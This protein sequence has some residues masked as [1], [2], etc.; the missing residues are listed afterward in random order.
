MSP[1]TGADVAAA[2]GPSVA[3]V[4]A[5][6][7]EHVAQLEGASDTAAVLD[8]SVAAVLALL[9]AS[10]VVVVQ[11]AGEQV[12]APAGRGLTA[13]QQSWFQGPPSGLPGWGQL[14]D[15][16]E[17]G[18]RWQ[19]VAGRVGSAGTGFLV[20]AER[21][22]DASTLLYAL[23]A[24]PGDFAPDDALLLSVLAG[25]MFAALGRRRLMLA[26]ERDQQQAEALRQLTGALSASLDSAALLDRYCRALLALTCADR[27]TVLL[28]DEDGRYLRLG[29]CRG[30][31][32]AEFTARF[33]AAFTT[34]PI[35]QTSTIRQVLEGRATQVR[36][37]GLSQ[38]SSFGTI[39][40]KVSGA[41]WAAFQPLLAGE[42]PIG[43]VILEQ[44]DPDR[45][46]QPDQIR[47]AEQVSG[48]AAVTLQHAGLYERVQRA[49][50]QL[51]ALHDVTLAISFS[52]SLAD[53]LQH[54]TDAAARLTGA[55]RCRLGLREGESSYRMAAVTGDTDDV[56]A[57]Y[58]LQ[59]AI[60]GWIIRTGHLAWLP[61]LQLGLAEP[62]ETARLARRPQGSA[63][64][65]P[66]LGRDRKTLGFLSLH[67][68]R[69][70][71]FSREV[72]ALAERFA[73]EAVLAVE[74]NAEV[75]GR[76]RLEDQLRE[77]AFHDPLTGLANRRLFTERVGHALELHARDH[78][79]L[80][81]LFCDLDDFK[82]VNDS[83]GHSTGDALLRSVGERLRGVLRSGDTLARLGGD[84]F[85]VL[86]EDQGDPEEVGRRIAAALLAP[87]A[88]DGHHL[89]VGGSVGIAFV[90]AEEGAPSWQAMLANA[91]VAMYEAKRAGKNQL[92]RYRPGLRL[93]DAAGA[94]LRQ[95]FAGALRD[96]TVRA[97]FQPI[98]HLVGGRLLGFEAL[99]RLDLDGEPVSP[100][101]F[102]P[103]AERQA[104]IAELTDQMLEQAC[105]R[106]A[107]W[108]ARVGH[109]E[110]RVGVNVS[111][112]QLVE[113][114]FVGRV[115]EA[116]ARHRIRP[117]QLVLEITE[118]ALI[119]DPVLAAEVSAGL[120]ALGVRLSLD[121]FGVG[122]S[123]LAHLHQIPL[124]S[125]KIDRI[126]I[127]DIAERPENVRML[128]GILR[129]A[130]ELDLD[131][132]AEGI[133]TPEQL[134]ILRELGCGLGQGYLLGMPAPA[135][136][137]RDL[138]E[139]PSA[140]GPRP[141]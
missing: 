133:E 70:G 15:Q 45:P 10:A 30:A 52:E 88:V 125:I 132:V 20:C 120:V 126:F 95:S 39:Y 68:H 65:V 7:L 42:I 138:L 79:P 12:S 93:A 103:L 137:W 89:L 8:T 22:G 14:P 94:Q 131:V 33:D 74:N 57:C 91:D 134:S 27:A 80:A 106:L 53:T 97:V 59:T 117:G 119:T 11:T 23:A 55:D 32:S 90:G 139:A 34:I 4:A 29:L 36:R 123:S 114:A 129:L 66:L 136:H 69:A 54:I 62:P 85:A 13:E 51:A 61:D 72:S 43:L 41:A 86:L 5:A 21:A 64:G 75:E 102:V 56:G 1:R 140:R 135:E 100:E 71:H 24:P 98:F 67:H 6:A 107:A 16:P 47:T 105:A 37:L 101:V 96:G 141:G 109:S 104:M 9:N 50:A 121:D 81:V 115:A 113:R 28:M 48:V 31:G 116:L 3:A 38:P 111:S 19:A 99:A 87:F 83:Y 2:A 112:Q 92:C 110:L 108:S 127:Q 25:Q 73:A 60:G 17:A 18:K 122:Y 76:R 78:R 44:L 63:L 84:E 82:H 58:D 118:R 35:D 128:R 40:R 46:L 130:G 26:A 124:H 49:R 77:Q